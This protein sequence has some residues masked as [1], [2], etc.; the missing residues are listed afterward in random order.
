MKT[1]VNTKNNNVNIATINSNR[2]DAS[3]YGPKCRKEILQSLLN[4]NSANQKVARLVAFMLCEKV[5]R[6][7]F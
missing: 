6:S 2:A 5:V 3:G 4:C 1:S 7:Y